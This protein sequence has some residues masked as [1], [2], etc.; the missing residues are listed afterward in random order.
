MEESKHFPKKRVINFLLTLLILFSTSI[1]IGSKYQ[2]ERL[3]SKEVA[4]IAV[5]VFIIYT[6]VSTFYN[7]K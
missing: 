1:C 7:A 4:F 5:I 3:V 2:K 6:V